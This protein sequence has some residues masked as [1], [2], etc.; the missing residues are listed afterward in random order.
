VASEEMRRPASEGKTGNADQR[1]GEK[2]RGGMKPQT[3][4]NGRKQA[5]SPEDFRKMR[6]LI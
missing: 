6:K 1:T 3:H 5:V 2:R 4:K